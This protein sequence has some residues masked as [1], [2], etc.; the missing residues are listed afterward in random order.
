MRE[1]QDIRG[2]SI[3]EVLM[4]VGVLA[5]GMLFV[6]GV[7]PV[8]IYF[9]TISAERTTAAVVAD[10]AFAKIKLYGIDIDD[11]N[12]VSEWCVDFNDV[13]AETI[14]EREYLYPSTGIKGEKQYCWSAICRD[15]DASNSGLVQVTVF[16]SRKTSAGSVYPKAVKVD[17]T[18][19]DGGNELKITGD[20]TYI[21]DGSR[22]VD[23]NMGIIYRVLERYASNDEVILLD[24]RWVDDDGNGAGSMWVVPPPVGGGRYPC[25][26]V[27]QRAIR[28]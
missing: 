18:G 14:A 4:A 1:K 26:A 9:A 19:V 10:E 21:N 6:A 25:I 7:F 3:V 22:I 23:D 11:P 5:V 24:K 20:K 2:F 28:F 8:G 27:Y 15:A 17:V 13:A 16:V 12:L